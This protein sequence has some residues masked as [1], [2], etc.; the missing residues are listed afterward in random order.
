M[1][2]FKC[3][4]VLDSNAALP[5]FWIEKIRKLLLTPTPAQGSDFYFD[6]FNFDLHS[7]RAAQLLT[8]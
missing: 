7:S 5:I 3:T 6:C 1:G 8:H 4:L 2:S